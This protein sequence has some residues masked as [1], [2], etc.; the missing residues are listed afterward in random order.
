[1]NK[2]WSKADLHIH[3][4]HSSDATASVAEVLAYAATQTDL[5]VIAITDHDSIA[6]ALEARRLAGTYGIEVIVGEEV[7]TAEGHLLAL[8]IE[9]WLPPGQPAAETI[10]AVHAQGGLA[11]AAHPYGWAVPSLGW[12]GLYE[13]AQG[14]GSAWPLDGIEGFNASLLL[15]SNNTTATS[16]A[17]ALGLALCGGSDSH[18][19][20]TIGRG[21]T[22]FPGQ[23]AE[24]LRAALCLRQTHA[25]GRPW[26]WARTVEYVG[27]YLRN[28][29]QN[30]LDQRIRAPLR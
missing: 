30:M 14:T 11:I 21:Y 2:A 25:G 1:M 18:H 8:F 29:M 16:V 26:G 22:L 13:R 4:V 27:L 28:T 12:N 15:P 17:A 7:S 19:L 10:A 9:Q 23:T 24:D 3:T 6:G 5:Q 20:A